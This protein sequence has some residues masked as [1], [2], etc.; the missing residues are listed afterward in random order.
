MSDTVTTFRA[1]E[2]FYAL[3]DTFIDEYGIEVFEK[4]NN[5]GT[6]N[7]GASSW[8]DGKSLLKGG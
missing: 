2:M 4:N 6:A 5:F 3:K 1:M 7:E 8:D